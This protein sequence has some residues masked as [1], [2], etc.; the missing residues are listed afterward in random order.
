MTFGIREQYP[1][2]AVIAGGVATE[3]CRPRRAG[4]LAQAVGLSPAAL[5]RHLRAL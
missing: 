4:E 5:T 1:Q 2:T 3:R